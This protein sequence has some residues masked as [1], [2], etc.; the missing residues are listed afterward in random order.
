VTAALL[1]LSRALFSPGKACQ[2]L[3][4]RPRPLLL[5][6][7]LAGVV[8]AAGAATLPRQ[9]SML[10]QALG[11]SGN[12]LRDMQHAAMRPG[13]TRVIVVD[14]LV[15]PPT[16]VLA[17]LLLVL[18]V[19]PVLA[20][21]EDRRRA[22]WSVVIAGL[23]PLVLQRTGELLVS[24]LAAVPPRP[25]PG[26]PIALPQRFATGALLFW[27][28]DEP[29]PPWLLALNARFSLFAGWCVA[30]WA[31][32]LRRLDRE[33]AGGWHV[34]LP[35]G[36]LVLAALVTYWLRPLAAALVLGAP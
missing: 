1:V 15:P 20:V 23:T 8:T 18:A 2:T 26:D 24:Y 19:D 13:L 9:L 28:Q 30:I 14:R 7:V 35:A 16:V 32:G 4:D 27:W 11:P 3:A 29:A 12:V 21:A 6:M 34:A 17:A 25:V 31:V 5:A 36:C 10:N 33:P 22:L